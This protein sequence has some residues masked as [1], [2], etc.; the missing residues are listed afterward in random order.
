MLQRLIRFR[1]FVACFPLFWVTV[2]LANIL[3][4]ELLDGSEKFAQ[5]TLILLLCN[6]H[7]I[8]I[9][10]VCFLITLFIQKKFDGTRGEL[11]LYFSGFALSLIILKFDPMGY[12]RL[13]ID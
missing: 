12:F 3:S 1:K 9:W 8:W 7:A 13:I 2:F 4:Y 6:F 11:L 5:F 10:L